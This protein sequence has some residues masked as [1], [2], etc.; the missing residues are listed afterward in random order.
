VTCAELATLITTLTNTVNNGFHQCNDKLDLLV[1]DVADLKAKYTALEVTVTQL[2]N[3]RDCLKRELADLREAALATDI[4]ARESNLVVSGFSISKLHPLDDFRLFLQNKL[5][6]PVIDIDSI[7]RS[8][9][10]RIVSDGSIPTRKALTIVTLSTVAV[11]NRLLA[12]GKNLKGTA[13]FIHPDLPKSAQDARKQLRPFL[14]ASRAN[15]ERSSF[16]G[17]RLRIG[18]R[19]FSVSDIASLTT[20]YPHASHALL[21]Q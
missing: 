20:R 18:D 8:A 2:S 19:F 12:L 7:C 14:I 11:R 3:D 10:F 5:H 16:V 13:I 1:A 15:N 17:S 4:T 9:S 21:N 6:L